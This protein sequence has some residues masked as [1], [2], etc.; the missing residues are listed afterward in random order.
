VDLLEELVEFLKHRYFVA[1]LTFDTIWLGLNHEMLENSAGLLAPDGY[2]AV[3]GQ[4]G[5]HI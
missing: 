1:R 3:L 4:S 5:V 2:R